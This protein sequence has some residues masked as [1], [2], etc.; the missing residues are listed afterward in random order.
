MSETEEPAVTVTET[1]PTE[2]ATPEVVKT[3]PAAPEGTKK[4]KAKPRKGR[5]QGTG[6]RASSDVGG[7]VTL[8][9]A[10]PLYL[11]TLLVAR[12]APDGA[13]EIL[14]ERGWP[15]HATL[16]IT[17]LAVAILAVKA[18]G[19][20]RQRRAFA[21]ELLPAA[22]EGRIGPE[23]AAN[24]VDHATSI[25]GLGGRSFLVERVIRVLSHF[26]ARGDLAEATA[27]AEAEAEADGAAVAQSFSTV[28]V[29]VWA[30]PILGLIGTVIGLSGAVGAFSH[31]MSGAEQLDSIKDSLRQV[32]T[33]LAVAFDATFVALLASILVMLPMTAL[34]K[35]E[36]K[37]I[38]EVDDF[39]ATQLLPRLG[40]RAEPAVA[41][42]APGPTADAIGKAVLDAVGT[43]L[44]SML[45]ALARILERTAEEQ[46]GLAGAQDALLGRISDAAATL[47]DAGPVLDRAASALERATAAV[48]PG[49]ERVAA[50]MDR[51]TLAM[52]ASVGQLE[53]TGAGVAAGLERALA[54]LERTSAPI[55]QRLLPGVERAAAQLERAATD[56]GANVDRAVSQL[57][58]STRTAGE[59]AGATAR[60]QDQLGRELGASRQLLSLL[61]AGLGAGEA[62]RPRHANGANGAGAA[63][64]D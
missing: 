46:M 36:D 1:A 63:K 59:A 11:L 62:A 27:A 55:E 4:A 34:Q 26:A 61:A 52:T 29:L 22:L 8:G 32:T 40:Q 3:E 7:F 44:A 35:A 31:A 42:R 19:L 25:R 54:Q 64:G 13:R 41:E 49:V 21:L 53:R 9:I 47:K 57:E 60:A 50:D 6:G 12:F 38:G 28:K 23:Q 56:L 16:M 37:L 5:E 43:P 30:M 2:P 39:C 10:V 14:L 24:L 15:P 18:A 48:G 33:G 51:A 17:S 58:A 20:R 45:E